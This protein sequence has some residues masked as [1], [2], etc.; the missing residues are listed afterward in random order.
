MP[1]PDTKHSIVIT[2]HFPYRGGT[3]NWT[4]RYHFEGALPTDATAWGA[5]AD[6]IVAAEKAIYNSDVT[7]VLATGYDASTASSTNPHGDAVWTGTYATAGTLS[8]AGSA[9]LAPGDGAIYLRYSTPARSSRNHPVYLSNY[10]HGALLSALGG[11]NLFTAQHTAVDTYAGHWL[12]GFLA[13]GSPRERCGPR[14]A[15]ATD[16]YVS[17]YIRHRDFPS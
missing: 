17:S 13:D 3:R 9:G 4:N 14:G 10:F 5:F 6:L 2:K 12:T 8:D 1:T 15:V 11:D 16:K 7:I